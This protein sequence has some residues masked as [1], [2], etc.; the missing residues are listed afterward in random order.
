MAGKASAAVSD[1]RLDEVA[2][3]AEIVAETHCPTGR[4]EPDIIAANKHVTLSFGR[5]GDALDGLLEHAA[6]RFHIYCNLDRVQ[7]RDSGRA[8]FTLAHE[9]GHFFIDDHRNALA[10]GIVPSHPSRCDFQS[11]NPVEVEADHF[12]ATLLMPTDR[13]LRV[14]G[15][16]ARGLASIL[17]LAESF[18]TSATSTA[19]R[20]V[21]LDAAPCG[22]IKWNPDG[23]AW[24]WCSRSMVEAGYRGTLRNPEQIPDDAPTKRAMRGE[25]P[26][27]GSFFQSGTVASAWFPS[28]WS[29]TRRD[30]ILIEEA[31]QLGRFGVLTLLRPES[32]RLSI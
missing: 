18:G 31:V 19:L 26:A 6:A 12:A 21:R 28:A 7:T 23:F 32:P 22:V 13:F 17:A 16:E 29:G 8:R 24:K 11:R 20:F 5:Y 30:I 2:E 14:A 9:L 25:R 27:T 3:L 1:D 15:K 4:V 10:A